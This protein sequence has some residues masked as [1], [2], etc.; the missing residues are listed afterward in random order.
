MEGGLSSLDASLIASQLPP[1]LPQ[2]SSLSLTACTIIIA[3]SLLLLLWIWPSTGTFAQLELLWTVAPREEERR[4]IWR[5]ILPPE[6][7]DFGEAPRP[8]PGTSQSSYFP[9][10]LSPDPRKQQQLAWEHKWTFRPQTESARDRTP[11]LVFINRAS[12]GR[13]GE[14]TLV[15]LRALLSPQQVRRPPLPPA[16]S[17]KRS[18]STS[19]P[20]RTCPVPFTLPS[21]SA[22]H[23][24]IA[25]TCRRHPRCDLA[26]RRWWT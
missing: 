20:T 19:T 18:T 13:Q 10:L 7:L 26:T 25:L 12:G 17:S 4:R 15:Q 8:S 24:T 23:A 6:A 1:M 9:R 21:P 22:V 11:L 2:Q 14:A 16:S 3:A 5:L